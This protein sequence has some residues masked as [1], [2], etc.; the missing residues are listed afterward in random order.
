M[1]QNGKRKMSAETPPIRPMRKEII[2]IGLDIL[3]TP[4]LVHCALLSEIEIKI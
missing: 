4:K 1:N 2:H 3:L